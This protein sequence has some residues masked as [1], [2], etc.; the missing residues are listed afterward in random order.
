[1]LD[2]SDSFL[3]FLSY[4]ESKAAENNFTLPAGLE[5]PAVFVRQLQ[6]DYHHPYPPPKKMQIKDTGGIV[7]SERLKVTSLNGMVFCK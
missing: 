6:L 7:Y 1:M 3:F 2:S 4:F 5:P